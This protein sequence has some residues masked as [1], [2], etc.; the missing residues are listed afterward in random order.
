ML[1]VS[2]LLT[3]VQ[4]GSVAQPPVASWLHPSDAAYQAA[5]QD[6]FTGK[7]KIGQYNEDK[8]GIH[9]VRFNFT[10]ARSKYNAIIFSLHFDAP[11]SLALTRG[12]SFWIVPPFPTCGKRVTAS[13]L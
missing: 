5:V 4:A 1:I 3:F 7:A 11:S 6:G 13:C 2:L 12:R 9:Q 10:T 8:D